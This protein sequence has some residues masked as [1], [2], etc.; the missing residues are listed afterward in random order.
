MTT[1]TTPKGIVAVWT[2]DGGRTTVSVSD[3]DLSGYGGFTLQRSQE[4][5]AKRSLQIEIVKRYCSPAVSDVLESYDCERIVD[6][7]K[8]VMSFIP[9]GHENEE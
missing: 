6:K 2:D 1:Q 3:F 5:R 4:I 7:M 8:G 9:V